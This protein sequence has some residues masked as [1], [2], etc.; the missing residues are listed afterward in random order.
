[1]SHGGL[2]YSA[3]IPNCFDEVWRG[4]TGL[5][6]LRTE[7]NNESSPRAFTFYLFWEDDSNDRHQ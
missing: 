4:T 2:F 6:V 3:F 5:K 7:K 1:M